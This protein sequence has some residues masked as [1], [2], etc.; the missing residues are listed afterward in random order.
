MELI[1]NRHV[2]RNAPNSRELFFVSPNYDDAVTSS[3]CKGKFVCAWEMQAA[4]TVIGRPIQSMY[5]PRNGLLDK[6]IGILNTVFTPVSSKSKKEPLLIMW[7]NAVF[8]FVGSW[9]PNH[10]VPLVDTKSDSILNI[11]DVDAFPPLNS[12][13][14]ESCSACPTIFDETPILRNQEVYDC[15]DTEIAMSESAT[16]SESAESATLSDSAD[17]AAVS[18]TA[19]HATVSGTAKHATV[20]GTAKHATVS[21]TAK[22]ATVSGTAKHITVSET[23]KHTT[24]SGTAKHATVSGTAKHATVSGTAKHATVS[25]TAKHATV[26]G[27]AKHATVSGT[28]K[29]APVSGI[30]KRAKLS[31]RS[32]RTTVSVSAKS[33]TVSGSAN[34]ANESGSVNIANESECSIHA[35]GSE[36]SINATLSGSAESVNL[37]ETAEIF[38]PSENGTGIQ[39][40]H[41][42]FGTPIETFNSLQESVESFDANPSVLLA[43]NTISDSE[44]SEILE[45]KSPTEKSL[46]SQFSQHFTNLSENKFI[47]TNKIIAKL[48]SFSENEVLQEM[49][50]CKKEN[51]Y[52]L[53]DNSENIVK[54]EKGFNMEFWDN[55]GTWASKS[56]SVKT[57]YFVNFKGRVR[58]ILK[59]ASVYGI[60]IKKNFV[61]LDPQPDKSEIFV[62]KR[63]YGTL[64]RDSNYKKR[65]SWFE[66][67][68]GSSSDR[69]KTVSL[70]EYL[71]TFPADEGS[72]HGN[73]RKTK[74]EYIRTSPITKK[75]ILG[76]L[77]NKQTVREIFKEHFD[78]EHAPRDTK[79]VENMKSKLSKDANPGN[80]QNTADD[81]QTI[82]NL[83]SVENPFAREV[84]QLAGK[85]PNLICYTDNQLKHLSKA[86]KT[87][88]IGIDRTFNL[89]P[90]FVTTTVFQDQN[91]K[92]KGKDVS[93]IL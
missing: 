25:G 17:H 4:T 22:H 74:Q 73:A 72:K 43:D 51:V 7:S 3:A 92:R 35:T 13:V 15:T 18:G 49:P 83:T 53:L 65:I 20:S 58:S 14:N 16:I 40:P 34:I 1:K 55:C 30:T 38:S 63:Y 86:C 59:K 28:A 50:K 23:A 71:G 93:P 9:L 41:L 8:S 70:V 44:T 36:S 10:F 57:T 5:P 76:A 46:D 45:S 90:C 64:E 75:N 31:L 52:F 61:P 54:K 6:A 26:S 21:G 60:E 37:S 39:S 91:L 48:S 84:V 69:Y 82:L 66:H 11:Y 78:S 2:Y 89:G 32:K 77:N 47:D 24:K 62:L 12:T 29:H 19:K 33:A 81:I 79:M 42:H 56:L 67:M 87:S 80:R 68:P 85:P 88:V 27:T